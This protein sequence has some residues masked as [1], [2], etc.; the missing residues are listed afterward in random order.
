[1]LPVERMSD[2]EK[3]TGGHLSP[4]HSQV[5]GIQTLPPDPDAHLSQEEREKIV[6]M[7]PITVPSQLPLE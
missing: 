2:I 7:I 5:D 6:C 1:M 3:T 4:T